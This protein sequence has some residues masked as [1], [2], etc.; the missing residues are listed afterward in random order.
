MRVEADTLYDE[1]PKFFARLGV[2][3]QAMP[4]DSGEVIPYC[5]HVMKS[6]KTL[7]VCLILPFAL[8]ACDQKTDEEEVGGGEAAADTHEKVYSEYFGMM[9]EALSSMGSIESKETAD[10]F[11]AKIYLMVPQLLEIM[12][13]VKALPEPSDEEK[14]SA[15]LLH[16]KVMS[17]IKLKQ[18]LDRQLAE[19][20]ELTPEA[21]A[22]IAAVSA[23]FWS[24]DFGVNMKVI[25]KQMDAFYGLKSY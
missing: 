4:L 18:N 5:Q 7:M 3:R 6:L 10:A 1:I 13:R 22:A 25:S 20:R 24:G 23:S 19:T 8:V 14:K 17:R 12:N 16:A 11:L 2:S 21:K 9:E 15:Q